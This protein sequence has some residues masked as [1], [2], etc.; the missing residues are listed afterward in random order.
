MNELIISMD[1][2]EKS[3]LSLYEYVILQLVHEDLELP[4]DLDTHQTIKELENK[5]Y[6][7]VLE[8]TIVLRQKGLDIFE[9]KQTKGVT[10]DEFWEEY[11]N[12]SGLPKTD[13]E[14]ARKYWNSLRVKEKK[15]AFERITEY[16]NNNPRF[17]KKAR[18]Y[19]KD[20]NF[21]DEY[22]T[23]NQEGDFTINA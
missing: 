5:M 23:T 19:L 15:L 13:R 21:Y 11:H 4:D 7:K 14:A 1:T 20:K 22:D 9:Q 3:E 16:C 8:D 2:F 10:F 6:V 17:R 12:I 18:T